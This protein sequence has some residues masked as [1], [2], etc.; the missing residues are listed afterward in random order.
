MI[1]PN[2]SQDQLVGTLDCINSV[3]LYSNLLRYTSILL[4]GK[5]RHEVM[6]FLPKIT[7]VITQAGLGPKTVW[8]Q[9]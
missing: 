7:Q 4:A 8:L 6:E 1:T 9:N 5:I 3:N 2:T